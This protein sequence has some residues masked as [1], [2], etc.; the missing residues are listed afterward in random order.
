M[1]HR[2]RAYD[3]RL[4]L[5]SV[6]ATA[7]RLYTA[8]HDHHIHQ[9]DDYADHDI[10]DLNHHDDNYH[11]AGPVPNSEPAGCAGKYLD[12]QSELDCVNRTGRKLIR[13]AIP[14]FEYDQLLPGNSA[15][16]Q[17]TGLTP[18]TTYTAYVSLVTVD[19]DS[20]AAERS[21]TMGT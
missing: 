5:Q 1:G 4:R 18:G 10:D 21:F 14:A 15:T 11:D 19:G 17:V 3:H 13:V 7:G 9:H 2:L 16:H 6:A 8:D 12:S 20:T